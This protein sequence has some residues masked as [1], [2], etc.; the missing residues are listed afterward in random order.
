MVI[1]KHASPGD[2]ICLLCIFLSL[3][4]DMKTRHAR[5]TTRSCRPSLDTLPTELL[6]MIQK[7]RGVDILIA[8]IHTYRV[9]PYLFAERFKSVIPAYRARN[10]GH[11]MRIQ[12][13]HGKH[14]SCNPFLLFKTNFEIFHSLLQFLTLLIALLLYHD[15]FMFLGVLLHFLNLIAILPRP[16][17]S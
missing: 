15:A 10:S 13:T 2:L 16:F 1:R 11:T 5:R 8:H 4:L 3:P 12:N 7:V 17:I 9:Y 14:Y 6:M